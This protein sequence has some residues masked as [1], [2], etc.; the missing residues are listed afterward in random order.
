MNKIMDDEMFSG[1][2]SAL[3]SQGPKAASI[4]DD[5][6][7]IAP[8]VPTGPAVSVAVPVVPVV[9]LAAEPIKASKNS[10]WRNAIIV[11]GLAFMAWVGLKFW[12]R[13]PYG[14]QILPGP[15]IVPVAKELPKLQVKWAEEPTVKPEP[16]VPVK[17]QN[18][19][20]AEDIVPVHGR[21]PV[22]AVPDEVNLEDHAAEPSIDELVKRREA[23]TKELETFMASGLKQMGLKPVAP[24]V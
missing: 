1:I 3:P 19:P 21:I 23:A 7:S 22:W 11:I 4:I 5:A 17:A 14:G 8:A 10:M 16:I 20:I 6:S 18:V 2:L 24:D 13:D 9:P 12:R 15:P